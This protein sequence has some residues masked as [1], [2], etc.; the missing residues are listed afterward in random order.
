VTF[1]QDRIRGIERVSARAPVI[2]DEADADLDALPRAAALGYGG[3]SMKN[4]KGVFRAV[5]NRARCDL[6]PG[7][8]L[9]GEDL[10]TLP[11]IPL[12]QDLATVALLGPTHV[13]RNGH[14]Y[15]KGLAHLP[16]VEAESA[17]EHHG[18]LYEPLAGDQVQLRIRH[19]QLSLERLHRIGFGYAVPPDVAARTPAA[20]WRWTE[21]N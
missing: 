12:Q 13:E 5:L 9:S 8:L 18:D 20:E 1:N 15:F 6:N 16:K 17:L 7:L 14:H 19:G 21:V 10:T 4:C 3:V 2:I 11:I